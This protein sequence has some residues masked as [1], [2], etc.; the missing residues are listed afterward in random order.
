MER[1]HG[2]VVGSVE[3]SQLLWWDAKISKIPIDKC[4]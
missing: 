2:D 3:E 1:G 4:T